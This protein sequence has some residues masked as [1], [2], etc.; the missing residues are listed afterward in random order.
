MKKNV[1]RT[2]MILTGLVFLSACS[3]EKVVDRSVDS[4]LFVGRTAVKGTV[5]AGKL[6]VRGTGA[7]VN[8]A[9]GE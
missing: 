8:A 7:V 1:M 5:G 3:A 6:V 2:I 4:A 9:S